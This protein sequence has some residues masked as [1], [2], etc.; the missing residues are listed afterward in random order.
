MK[1]TLPKKSSDIATVSRDY[2]IVI[3]RAIRK[4]L[5]ITPGQ[6]LYVM[7]QGGRI[8]IFLLRPIE[9]GRGFVSEIDVGIE[10]EPDRL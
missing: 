9:Q 3:P 10:R 8:E 2:R 6:K 7:Q 1:R 4:A 5:G